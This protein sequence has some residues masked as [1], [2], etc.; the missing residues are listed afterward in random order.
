MVAMNADNDEENVLQVVRTVKGNHA[1]GHYNQREINVIKQEVMPKHADSG[2]V[3][4]ITPYR[5]QPN[6]R[7]H[8][9]R[10]DTFVHCDQWK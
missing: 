8:F 1:R 4:I 7:S 10:Q 5:D 6:E 3:G 9:S 2:S